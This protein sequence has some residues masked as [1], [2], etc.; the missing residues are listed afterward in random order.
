VTRVR[1]VIAWDESGGGTPAVFVH[2][3]TEDRHS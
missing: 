3:I 2:G 1:G